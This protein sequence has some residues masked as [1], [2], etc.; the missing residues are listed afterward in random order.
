M[1]DSPRKRKANQ[2]KTRNEKK[3]IRRAAG[4]AKKEC[5][6]KY[7]TDSTD[8]KKQLLDCIEKVKCI[9][10]VCPGCMYSS[11]V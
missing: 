3:K 8:D 1:S 5:K 9:I 6:I 2:Q 11:N 4:T 10:T 7:Y